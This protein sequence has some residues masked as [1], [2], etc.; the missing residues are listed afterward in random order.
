MQT[1]DANRC[2]YGFAQDRISNGSSAQMEQ[3]HNRIVKKKKGKTEI[4]RTVT[5][6]PPPPLPPHMAVVTHPLEYRFLY[7]SEFHYV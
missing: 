6:L 7:E 1:Q 2:M 4:K 5:P 3:I